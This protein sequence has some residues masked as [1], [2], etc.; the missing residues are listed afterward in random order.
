MRRVHQAHGER[1][2]KELPGVGVTGELEIE[3]GLGAERREL[4]IVGEEQLEVCVFPDGD[5][6]AQAAISGIDGA[7]D[8]KARVAFAD[9]FA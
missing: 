4:W 6:G 9:D 3:A 8:E 7:A 2:G 1:P 5:I